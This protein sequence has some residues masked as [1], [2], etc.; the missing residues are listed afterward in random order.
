MGVIFVFGNEDVEGDSLA[1]K[2]AKKLKKF[3]FYHSS[4]PESLLQIAEK[5]I[6]ILDVARGIDKVQLVKVENIKNQP[7]ASLHD[8]DLGYF[9][10]LIKELDKSK[11]FKIIAVPMEGN[12][13]EIAKEVELCI[14][15]A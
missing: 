12:V 4:R 1:L 2:V 14:R 11:K 9:L 10:R 15:R 8:F 7:K 3:K 6:T 5:D 13:D